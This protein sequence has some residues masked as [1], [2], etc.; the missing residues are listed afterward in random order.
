MSPQETDAT[1]GR[2]Y[3]EH[4]DA[5]EKRILLVE[6]VKQ[7]ASSLQRLAGALDRRPAFDEVSKDSILHEYL[8]LSK[9]AALVAEEAE[10][11]KRQL[12]YEDRLRALGF[13]SF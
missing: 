3:R 6:R 9:I 12:D 5:T 13:N 8:D 10:L 11:Q 2:L 4:K 7:V 1:I